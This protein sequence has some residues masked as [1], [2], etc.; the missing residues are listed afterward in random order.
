M[1][2]IPILISGKQ[3]S[4]KSTLAHK[5]AEG[6]QAHGGFVFCQYSFAA[7]LYEMHDAVLEVAR[8]YGL[9]VLKKDGPLLQLLGTEWGRKH[10]G[11][12]VWVDLV[13]NSIEI[14][15]K[16]L[17]CKPIAYVPII[18]DCR[19]ENEIEGFNEFRPVK[20]RL[21][22][23]SA[24]RKVRI[25]ATPGQCWR[26]NTNHPSEIGLDLYRKWDSICDTYK[27]SSDQIAQDVLKQIYRIIEE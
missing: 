2:I 23:P 20:I 22:C 11:E 5:V 27:F 19:F 7:P 15:A 6:L 24:I 14:D 9:K 13:K 12:N 1:K 17:N 3:G 26:E 8:G 18:S 25:E 16:N 21:E 10:F 4:G